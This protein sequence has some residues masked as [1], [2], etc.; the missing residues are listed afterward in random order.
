MTLI[1]TATALCVALALL[2]PNVLRSLG[3][4]VGLLLRALTVGAARGAGTLSA[5]YDAARHRRLPR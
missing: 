5:E 3:Y 4:A 1:I 2:A